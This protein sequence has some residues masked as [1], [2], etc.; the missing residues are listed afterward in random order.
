MTGFKVYKGTKETFI[1][2]GK[3][4]ENANAIVFITGGNDTNKSCIFAQGTYFAN[5]SEFISTYINTLNYVKGVNI[6][7]QSYNAATGGGYVAFSSK[8]P[9][10]IA[11]NEANNIEIGLSDDFINKINDIEIN[12]GSKTVNWSILEEDPFNGHEYVDLG[13]PSGTLWATS[14]IGGDNPLYFQWGDIEGWT[15]EQI[16]NGEKAFADS[17]YKWSDGS[18]LTKY[19]TADGNTVLDLEDDAAHVHMGGDWHMPTKEQLKELT[20]NTTSTWTTQNGVSGKLF[21]STINGESV[22]VPA[23]G[24]IDDG[25]LLNIGSFG[26]VWSSSVNEGSLDHAW[27]LNFSSSTVGMSGYGYR[28]CGHCVLGVINLKS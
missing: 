9:T 19:N 15:A 26:C 4:I 10:I 21:T 3:D 25:G 14:V 18:S 8:D 2:S 12:L 5:F 13:L 6:G 16:N 22:F 28:I 17:D 24:V 1:S 27:A 23:F 20:A 7:G 11:I